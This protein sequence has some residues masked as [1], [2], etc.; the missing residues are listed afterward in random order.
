MV[1]FTTRSIAGHFGDES[2]QLII[3]TGTDYHTQKEQR[4]L[5]VM[6]LQKSVI[7]H[8]CV[9]GKFPQDKTR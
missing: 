4:S 6:L 1:S 9:E 7:N 5:K 8:T 3:C 2:F